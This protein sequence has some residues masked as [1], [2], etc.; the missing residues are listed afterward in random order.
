[1]MGVKLNVR[2][3]VG[4]ALT[5]SN[6]VLTTFPFTMTSVINF[7][8]YKVVKVIGPNERKSETKLDSPERRAY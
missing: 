7:G 2:P 6:P 1:M 4:S 5:G 3:I 8:M